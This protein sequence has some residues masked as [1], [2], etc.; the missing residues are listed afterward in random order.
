[1]AATEAA[2]QE[3]ETRR[4]EAARHLEALRRLF[5]P[6]IFVG[7][8]AWLLGGFV[9]LCAAAYTHYKTGWDHPDWKMV[10]IVAGATL[11]VVT[12]GLVLLRI[13]AR[14]KTRAADLAFRAALAASSK[15]VEAQLEYARAVRE[16]RFADARLKRD[17]EVQRA[18]DHYLP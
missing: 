8:R 14:N 4:A 18:R 9:T 7:P 16:A 12:V 15:A 3:F 1:V 17:A 5:V 10:G 6:K 13:V 2:E 11:V